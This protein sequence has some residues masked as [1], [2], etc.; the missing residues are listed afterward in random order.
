M[1][2]YKQQH[3]YWKG[4][5]KNKEVRRGVWCVIAQEVDDVD[6][7]GQ[8]RRL[9]L[10]FFVFVFVLFEF[11]LITIIRSMEA[12]EV[13]GSSETSSPDEAIVNNSSSSPVNKTKQSLAF[14]IQILDSSGDK[15]NNGHP[16]C[17]SRNPPRRRN[18]N[19]SN[20][21]V[22]YISFKHLLLKSIFFFFVYSA[23]SQSSL[24]LIIPALLQYI[25]L[26]F[27]HNYN[28]CSKVI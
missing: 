28:G 21:K 10:C 4:F 6:K 23:Y 25:T 5:I 20:N 12:V 8:L 3:V 1:C 16:R 9:A 22:N 24:L 7:C 2:G 26:V 18:L 13:E 19:F 27:K 17:S 14:T 15:P 11:N